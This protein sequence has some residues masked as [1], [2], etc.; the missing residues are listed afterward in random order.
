MTGLGTG[1]NQ[2][3]G[4]WANNRVK[5]ADLPLGRRERTM[6]RFRQMRPGRGCR[7]MDADYV[8]DLVGGGRIITPKHL[9][10]SGFP[11]ASV[12]FRPS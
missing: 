3:V 6:L 8:A 5:N 9:D 10:L 12:A 7:D 11:L 4:R 2:E 1:E